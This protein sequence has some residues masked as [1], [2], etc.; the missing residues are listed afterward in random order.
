MGR[1]TKTHSKPSHQVTAPTAAKGK[2]L[3]SRTLVSL[4]RQGRRA[5]R[6]G[7]A[8]AVREHV[9][10][11]VLFGFV[12]E[13]GIVDLYGPGA[14]AAERRLIS[15]DQLRTSG[16]TREGQTFELIVRERRAGR[17]QRWETE[18]RPTVPAETF[19]PQP[20]L[21]DEAFERFRP[22]R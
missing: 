19:V 3:S 4:A 21:P 13:D 11:G 12:G 9:L 8:P 22:N 5:S 15:V 14:A 2:H 6:R 20:I 18:L 10:K 1:Y 7:P 17:I 16:I